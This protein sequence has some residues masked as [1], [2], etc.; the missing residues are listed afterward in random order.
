M[1]QILNPYLTFPGTCADAMRFYADALGGTLTLTTFRESGMDMD[2]VMHASVDTES[3]FHL[4]ASDD[5]PGMGP[6]YVHGNNIQISLS[7]DEPEPLRA[8]WAALGEGGQ[9]VVPLEVAPWGD[10]Y[11]QLIDRFGIAWHLNITPA[12]S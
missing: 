8:I 6:E 9:T 4:F 12:A 11:G 2:G 10:E 3:G 5:M 1:S 7:G